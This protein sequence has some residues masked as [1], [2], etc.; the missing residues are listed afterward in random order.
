M[1]ERWFKKDLNKVKNIDLLIVGINAR[2]NWK[3]PT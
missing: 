1:E 2:N 3:D